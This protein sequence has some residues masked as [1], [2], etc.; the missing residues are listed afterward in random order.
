MTLPDLSCDTPD[1]IA[2]LETARSWFPCPI[3]TEDETA[4]VPPG[5]SG[6]ESGDLFK[7]PHPYTVYEG[8]A[9]SRADGGDGAP[10]DN[11]YSRV[12]GL[13]PKAAVAAL[14]TDR[15]GTGRAEKLVLMAD[16]FNV[17]NGLV[18]SW[19]LHLCDQSSSNPLQPLTSARAGFVSSTRASGSKLPA[20]GRPAHS[21]NIHLTGSQGADERF[22]ADR[23]EFDSERQPAASASFSRQQTL[24]VTSTIRQ[25]HRRH[26]LRRSSG[27][28]TNSTACG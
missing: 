23:I 5:H 19:G 15:Q 7:L 25:R 6:A 2:F 4:A 8:A 1:G 9:R 21:N 28:M 18:T 17:A 20:Q 12:P 16:G 3:S 24:P 14:E 11:L 10:R 13:G 22:G 27:R 26:P